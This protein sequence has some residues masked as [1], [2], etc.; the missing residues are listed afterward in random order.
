MPDIPADGVYF[1]KK[2]DE[3]DAFFKAPVEHPGLSV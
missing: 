2:A 1:V 3:F